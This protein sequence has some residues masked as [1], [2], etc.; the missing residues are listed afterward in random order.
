MSALFARQGHRAAGSLK[1]HLH[2]PHI[3]LQ[4]EAGTMLQVLGREGHGDRTSGV[5]CELRVRRVRELRQSIFCQDL[6]WDLHRSQVLREET[7]VR[8][9]KEVQ[10]VPQLDSHDA[11]AAQS[12]HCE[13]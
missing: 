11:D 5:Y 12:A 10:G 2:R 6:L 1:W 4:D 8:M 9:L 13:F 7:T 3:R